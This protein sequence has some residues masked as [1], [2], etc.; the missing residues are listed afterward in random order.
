MLTHRFSDIPRVPS[1]HGLGIQVQ[2][3]ISGE[4]H[5]IKAPETE[6]PDEL[7]PDSGHG[8]PVFSEVNVGNVVSK[9]VQLS[10]SRPLSAAEIG[11]VEALSATEEV[12][13]Q[14]RRD[15]YRALLLQSNERSRR[16]LFK[17]MPEEDRMVAL[18]L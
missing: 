6:K 18:A 5:D 3:G 17:S 7:H 14:A 2:E 11:S 12:K 15:R 13:R 4:K 10:P 8:A 1:G 9:V 16:E